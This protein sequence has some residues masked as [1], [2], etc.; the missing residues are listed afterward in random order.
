MYLP[1]DLKEKIVESICSA[2][3]V[4][5]IILFG[6][7]ARGEATKSSDIDLYVIT[8]DDG[9]RPMEKGIKARL[10]LRWLRT[11]K[12]II[13]NTLDTFNLLRD[14]L[15]FIEYQVSREGVVLYSTPHV[16]E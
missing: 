9:T 4:E 8:V 14:D 13:V 12:D 5:K 1:D 16:Q 10:A 2:I 7:Y 15:E 6:S 11:D 3:P